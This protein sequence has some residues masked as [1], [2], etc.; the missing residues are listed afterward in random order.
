M[1]MEIYRGERSALQ[2]EVEDLGCGVG[3]IACP[4]CLGTGKSQ[5]PVEM[6]GVVECIDCKGTGRLLVGL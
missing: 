5:W 2:I 6:T 3:R 1:L 4:E